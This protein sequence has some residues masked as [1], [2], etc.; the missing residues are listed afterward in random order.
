MNMKQIIEKGAIHFRNHIKTED[1]CLAQLNVHCAGNDIYIR[2][3]GSILSMPEDSCLRDSKCNVNGVN[4]RI[5]ISNSSTLAGNCSI[6]VTGNGNTVEVGENCTITGC[7]IFITGDNNTIKLNDK[8]SVVYASFHVEGN[9]NS[10]EIEKGTS[11]HG[12]ENGIIEFVLEEETSIV[13]GEDC[14]ISNGVSF[15]SSDSHSILNEIGERI[16]PAGNILINDHVWIGMRS[17][18]LKN[19]VIH[20]NCI[21][22][23]GSIC[24][25]DYE[26]EGCL[27]AGNPAKPVK[28]NINWSR[29]R[30]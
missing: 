18:I 6:R 25:K 15:R 5:I 7:S 1:S 24:N 23:T 22:G 2:G 20:N 21:V 10:V 29:D 12:R 8:V 4:N 19:T 26:K 13:I 16:N 3:K 14:M 9:D 27:I 28:E 11:I 17:V 30:L